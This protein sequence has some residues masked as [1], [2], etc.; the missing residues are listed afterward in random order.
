MFT[1]LNQSMSKDEV[2]HQVSEI[3]EFNDY[4][5]IQANSNFM[6]INT[7]KLDEERTELHRLSSYVEECARIAFLEKTEVYPVNFTIREALLM[8]D[9]MNHIFG[10]VIDGYIKAN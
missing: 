10:T 1:D 5:Y 6:A 3:I 7:E 9:E 4:Y 8:K 2:T